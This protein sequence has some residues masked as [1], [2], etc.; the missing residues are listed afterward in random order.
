ML[1][2]PVKHGQQ[3]PGI[4]DHKELGVRSQVCF[5]VAILSRIKSLSPSLASK[6]KGMQVLVR[7]QALSGRA[8]EEQEGWKSPDYTHPQFPSAKKNWQGQL[9][10]PESSKDKEWNAAS[11]DS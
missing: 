9:L 7:K 3:R 8:E 5:R 2:P 1:L 6:I 11:A 4:P 10:K